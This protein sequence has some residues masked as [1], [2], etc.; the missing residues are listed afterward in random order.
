VTVKTRPQVPG[1][2]GGAACWWRRTRP[3]S[4]WTWTAAPKAGI[5]LSYSDIDKA[6]T[7]FVWGPEPRAKGAQV[8]DRA[9]IGGGPPRQTEKR[10]QVVTP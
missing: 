5:H 9:L 7:V 4:S 1:D 6:R 10:K 3:V 8:Q 2:R